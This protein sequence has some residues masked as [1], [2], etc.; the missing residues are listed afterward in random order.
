MAGKHVAAIE[1]ELDVRLMQRS[2]RRLVLTEAGRAYYARCKR[3]IADYEAARREARET[4][5]I[6]RGVLRIAAP[7]TYGTLHLDDVLAD[8]LERHPSVSLEIMLSDSYVDLLAE[9]VDV[10]IRVGT[11]RDSD[12]VARR[13]APCRMVLCASPG[14]LDRRGPLQTVADLR[15]APRLAF[16]GAVSAGDWTLVDSGGKSHLIDGPL[17]L[18]ANN[19]QLLLTAVLRGAG[20]AYGPSFVFD[21]HISSGDLVV[22][23][24]DHQAVDL[25]IQA[26]YPTNRYM[27]FTLRS[28]IDHLSAS[29][30]QD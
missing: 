17:R 26:V 30:R 4:H 18:T 19:M 27:S 21:A 11:L 20:V 8:F 25:A 12:L 10:A 3:I 15:R 1:A 28:F 22:L 16:S 7:V 9:G 5:H 24:P 6:V 14:F 29:L 2:T 23:L 13:L